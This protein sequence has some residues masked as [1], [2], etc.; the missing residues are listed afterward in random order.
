MLR[1]F[2]LSALISLPACLRAQPAEITIEAGRIN[3]AVEDLTG[4]NG[5][6]AS[7]VLRNDLAMSG[8]FN[9]VTAADA[10]FTARGA[11][12]SGGLAG[13]A[14]GRDGAAR[15]NKTFGG[16][17]R[18]ATHEFADSL[19]ETLTEG[20]QKGIA[21]SRV[22]FISKQ[23]GQKELYIMDIDG[24]NVRQLTNDKRI[25]LGPRFAPDGRRIA[26][27][28]YSSGYPD[29]WVV[30]LVNSQRQRIAAFPGVNQ[31]PAFSP[32]GTQIA[33][34]LSKDGNTDLYAMPATGGNPRRL[35]RTSGTE[36]TPTWSPD[37]RQIAFISDD[38]GNPQI[39]IIPVTGGALQRFNTFSTYTTE[40]D[41]SPDGAKLAYSI[42]SAGTNQIAVS[43]VRSGEQKVLTSSGLNETPGWTR[44]SRHLVYSRD[45]KIYLLDSVTRQ[46]IHINNGVS[47]CSEPAAS[48]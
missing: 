46:S 9:I 2:L 36:A 15:L 12:G 39:Y 29:V 35:S 4:P 24:A 25:S 1:L 13:S 5:A 14:A 34:I 7:K 17:W 22:A 8:V 48:R 31:S 27:T 10:Q 40:V 43:D 45:G 38:R 47:Q 11:F 3:I 33:L 21:T 30:D 42:R 6:E 19:V 32:D 37:G 26:Y 28:S 20:R 44:N 16:D 23:T 41:W 18:Q